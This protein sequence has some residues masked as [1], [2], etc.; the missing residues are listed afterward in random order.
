MTNFLS[1]EQTVEEEKNYNLSC[2]HMLYLHVKLFLS[3]VC[4]KSQSVSGQYRM[5]VRGGGYVWVESHSA[6]IPNIR[7]SKFKAS[8]HQQP[9]ILSITYVLRCVRCL[10]TGH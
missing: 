7:P 3:A 1:Q 2:A 5:L 4:L 9:V 8:G 10:K 6:V